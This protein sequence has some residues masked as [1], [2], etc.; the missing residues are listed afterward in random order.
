MLTTLTAAALA[1]TL[2]TAPAAAD[3]APAEQVA[4]TPPVETAGAEQPAHTRMI[5]RMET[6]VGTRMPQRVCMT[7][8]HRDAR[9]RDSRELVQRLDVQNSNRGRSFAACS[10]RGGD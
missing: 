5:C 8:G 10:G 3:A 7:Q 6:V 9:T 4:A 2:Q 1:L